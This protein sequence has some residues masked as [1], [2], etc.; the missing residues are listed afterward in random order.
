MPSA[1]WPGAAATGNDEQGDGMTWHGGFLWTARRFWPA[2]P[3]QHPPH[4]VREAQLSIAVT[5][6]GRHR[7]SASDKRLRRD[8]SHAAPTMRL[9]L[10]T[11]PRHGRA[12]QYS[13]QHFESEGLAVL[14]FTTSSYFVGSSIAVFGSAPRRMRS[15]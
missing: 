6:R 12:G 7:F 4:A 15:A 11:L 2:P 3:T 10:A 8:A 1:A 13:R 14:R 9:R 5:D